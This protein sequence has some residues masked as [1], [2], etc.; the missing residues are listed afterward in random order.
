MISSTIRCGL[1]IARDNW[2]VLGKPYTFASSFASGWRACHWGWGSGVE[3]L[4]GLKVKS[5]DVS[6]FR[7]L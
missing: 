7:K 1:E 5:L 3:D 2:T 6:Y 4:G